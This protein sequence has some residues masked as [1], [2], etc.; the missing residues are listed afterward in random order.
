MISRDG[1]R[2]IH[3][4]AGGLGPAIIAVFMASTVAVEVAGDVA[5]VVAVKRAIA[6]GLLL[7][8]PV[9]ATAGGTGFRLA[10]GAKAGPAARKAARMRVVAANGVLVL[11]P[12]A[13]FLAGRA[14]AGR[15]D[16][17]FY[18]V[19]AAELLAGATNL[20]LLGLNLRDG[21]AMAARRRR[22]RASGV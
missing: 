20:V 13:L 11:V 12:A 4:V 15:F 2:A 6:W 19:Q 8:V 18:A 21:L 16:G 1:I 17:L 10:G 22:A 7:L 9:L 3:A 5:A 14:A